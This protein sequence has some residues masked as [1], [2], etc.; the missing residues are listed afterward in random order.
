M[1]IGGHSGAFTNYEIR[2]KKGEGDW[3]TIK[4]ESR[5]AVEDDRSVYEI[6]V[7]GTYIKDGNLKLD[8]TSKSTDCFFIQPNRGGEENMPE[9]SC[10]ITDIKLERYSIKTSEKERTFY[11]KP[12]FTLKPKTGTEDFVKSEKLACTIPAYYL[13]GTKAHSLAIVDTSASSV[14][15]LLNEYATYNAQ[16]L[17]AKK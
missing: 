13:E 3:I 12:T 5:F 9:V 4:N 16:Y 8:N 10:N 6:E 11:F 14:A 2:Y 7:Y 15:R 1:Y 17:N